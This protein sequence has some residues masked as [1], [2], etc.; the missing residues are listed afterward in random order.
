[1]EVSKQQLEVN[2]NYET[3]KDLLPE[4]IKTDVNRFALMSNRQV[5][6]CFDTCRDANLAGKYLLNGKLFSIQQVT[7]KPLDLGSFSRGIYRR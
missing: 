7:D 4:L 2:E 1:M 6:A 5:L 3:F